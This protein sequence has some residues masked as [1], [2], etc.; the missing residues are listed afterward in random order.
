ML[1]T[2]S[3]SNVHWGNTVRSV[4]GKKGRTQPPMQASTWQRTPAAAAAEASAG[5]GSTTPWA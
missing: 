5:I 3:T 1:V 2:P 4:A